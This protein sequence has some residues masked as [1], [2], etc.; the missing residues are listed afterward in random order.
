MEEI[1]KEK[2]EN[3]NETPAPRGAAAAAIVFRFIES[4]EGTHKKSHGRAWGKQEGGGKK[5]KW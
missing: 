3:E 5:A 2:G 4:K 1:G